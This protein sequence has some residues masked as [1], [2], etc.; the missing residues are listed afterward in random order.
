MNLFSNI[1]GDI[2]GALS[3]AIITL[4]MCIGYG[5]IVFAPLGV[6]YAPQ[7]AMTGIYSAVFAGFL[8]SFFGGNPIQITGPKALLM[9]V[10]LSV[11]E[12]LAKSPHIPAD[13]EYRYVVIVGL[14]SVP[15]FIAGVFQ[16]V[17]ASLRLGNLTKYVPHPVVA[18]FTNA[19]G[20]LLITRQIRPLLGADTTASLVSVM[21]QITTIQPM[22]LLVGLITLAALYLSRHFIKVIPASLTALA[23]G[24]GMYYVLTIFMNPS[25]LGPIIGT[26]RFEW[27]RPDI[28]LQLCH[29]G[30]MNM[31]QI[32]LPDLIITGLFIALLSAMETLLSSVTS[33]NLTGNRH[34]SK[35]E[36]FG[37][38]I[39]NI[40]TSF[41]GSLAAAGSVPRTMANFKA[42]GSTPLSG[43]MCGLF[44]FLIMMA[45]GPMV[46]KV[47]MTVIAGI[48][49]AVGISLFDKWT[50]NFIRNNPFKQRRDVLINFLVTLIVTVVMVS[51]DTIL[52]V[53][54][55]MATA[56]AL[57]VSKMGKSVIKRKY[58]GE[59]FH[60]KK[61]RSPEHSEILI[62]NGRRIIVFELQGPIFFGSAEN[63]A[64]D[65]ESAMGNAVYCILDMKRVNEIDSTGAN[66]ILQI[67]KSIE[68]CGKYLLISY[69]RENGSLWE[70]LKVMDVVRNLDKEMV[71]PDTDRALEWAEDHLL[72]YR[73]CRKNSYMSYFLSK[74]PFRRLS[75]PPEFAALKEYKT[76]IWDVFLDDEKFGAQL[77][78]VSEGGAGNCNGV[79]PE[80]MEIVKGFTPQELAEFMQRLIR[81]TYKKGEAVFREGDPG[82]DLFLLTKGSVSVKIQLKES[83][84]FKR[85]I[86][87]SPGVI[88]GEVA[89]LDG[90]PRSAD[91]WAEEDAEVYRLS[92]NDFELL[93]TEKPQVVIKLL[94]NIA[95]E[96][97]RNLRRISN[98]VRALEDT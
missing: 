21:N 48:L 32:F 50:I 44:I 61:M 95:K 66:I 38:G 80:Q 39:G 68:K 77:P 35:R 26:I 57:F 3:A 55:G 54:I 9:F 90:K 91:V 88:F 4:P 42:G 11:V 69:L 49:I 53:E 51:V 5:I 46:G 92:L 82:E 29:M 71:F 27:P 86:T 60:S 75:E 24:T 28:F 10:Q 96:F 19:I 16:I 65:V 18:G 67:S 87:F 14:A 45:M 31:I 73:E 76:L 6:E 30:C 34:N 93:R 62:R 85:L 33:D 79:R 17:F 81:R 63:L 12:G 94:L 70:F 84:R 22:T 23:V 40:V 43:M 41:F 1:K 89:L 13:S 59:Q 20:I 56:S 37:Q 97:S 15:V 8:A 47:P 64:K 83:D 36:L 98:E 78:A 2:S 58:F 52:A 25:S 72:E 74:I 7:A